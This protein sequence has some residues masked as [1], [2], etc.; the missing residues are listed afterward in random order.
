[1]AVRAICVRQCGYSLGF[2]HPDPGRFSSMP[3]PPRGWRIPSRC[4]RCGGAILKSQVMRSGISP[5][6]RGRFRRLLAQFEVGELRALQDSIR[7]SAERFHRCAVGP[8]QR[9]C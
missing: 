3:P 6:L 9:N 7:V 5:N 8:V 4:P 1:M 2:S